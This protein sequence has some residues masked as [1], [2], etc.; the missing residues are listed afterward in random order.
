MLVAIKGRLVFI[1]P[2]VLMRAIS[3]SVAIVLLMLWFLLTL[4]GYHP[5][6]PHL[7]AWL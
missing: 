5:E 1:A 7:P 2:K 4:M 6:L 3:A